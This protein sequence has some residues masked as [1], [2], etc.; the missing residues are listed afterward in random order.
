M[1]DFTRRQYTGI[2]VPHHKSRWQLFIAYL[3]QASVTHSP[4]RIDTFN[5]EV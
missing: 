3:L 4:V 1:L 2:V 5:K